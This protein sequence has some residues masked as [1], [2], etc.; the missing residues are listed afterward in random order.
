MSIFITILWILGVILFLIMLV[1]LFVLFEDIRITYLYYNE[2]K[3]IKIKYLFIERV[4]NVKQINDILNAV[5]DDFT[6]GGKETTVDNLDKDI[7]NIIDENDKNSDDYINSQTIKENNNEIKEDKKAKKKKRKNKK[8]NK[9]TAIEEDLNTIQTVIKNKENIL[10]IFSILVDLKSVLRKILGKVRVKSIYIDI[11]VN[12]NDP[13]DTAIQYGKIN[14]CTYTL[15]SLCKNIVK[16]EREKVVIQSN[17]IN[18]KEYVKSKGNIEI[19]P[20]HILMHSFKLLIKVYK[21]LK[22]FI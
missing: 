16:I 13:Y 20:I 2:I 19:K 4:L 7:S 6:D 15:L 1:L 22:N 17:F 11:L 14:W 9:E 5:S 12:K 21:V 10:S 18:D 8:K 3:F